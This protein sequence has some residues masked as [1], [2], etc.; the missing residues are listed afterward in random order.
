LHEDN[1]FVTRDFNGVPLLVQNLGGTIRA[2]RNACAHRGMPLQTADCGNRKLICPYHG[3]SYHGDGR[4]RGIPNEKIYGICKS[5]QAEIRLQSYAVEVVGNFV[6]VNLDPNPLPIT[7]QFSDDMLRTLRAMS[8]HFAPEVSYTHLEVNFNWKLNFEN[9]LDWDHPR[10][11]HKN[12][13]GPLLEYASDGLAPA[14]QE[15]NSVLFGPDSDLADIQFATGVPSP[16]KVEL[17]DLSRVTRVSMPYGKRWFSKL[18]DVA[19]DPGAITTCQI[20]PNV[21]FG[22]IH[23]EQFYL[24]QFVPIAPDRF[25]Y[26]SWIFTARLKEGTPPQPQLLWGIHHAEKRV[27]DEDIV[28]LTALQRSLTGAASVGTMGD[29]ED[30][31]AAFGHC[32]MKL[33][34]A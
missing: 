17:I 6:F 33:I 34:N 22:C 5:D 19:A 28:L 10:F 2:F 13:F 12:T 27:V 30:A 1:S 14:P 31:I 26:H 7:D 16:D 4:L 8:G 24:Q 18:I 3:W 21:N 32:Y 23:G 11:V 9:I 29:H 20:F 15:H 25:H